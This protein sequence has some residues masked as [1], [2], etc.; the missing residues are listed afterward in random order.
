MHEKRSE[1]TLNYHRIVE[2]YTTS[3]GVV[4]GSI[5]DHVIFYVREGKGSHVVARLICSKYK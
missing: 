5:S 3:G 4:G 2:R 1:M